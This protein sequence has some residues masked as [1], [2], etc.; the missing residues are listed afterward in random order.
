VC[1]ISEDSE[2]HRITFGFFLPRYTFFLKDARGK[3][4]GNEVENQ[5]LYFFSLTVRLLPPPPPLTANSLSLPLRM[6]IDLLL[7]LNENEIERESER[8]GST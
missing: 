5:F 1:E 6:Y 3:C 4:N 2:L 8:G 7:N